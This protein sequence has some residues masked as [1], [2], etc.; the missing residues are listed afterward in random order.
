[1]SNGRFE[2]G[3]RE[4]ED[5]DHEE[6]ENFSAVS[7]PSAADHAGLEEGPSARSVWQ[8]TKDEATLAAI[9]AGP[10][11]GQDQQCSARAKNN[12]Y[13]PTKGSSSHRGHSNAVTEDSQISRRTEGLTRDSAMEMWDPT[14]THQ[15]VS[16]YH[17]DF[18]EQVLKRRNADGQTAEKRAYWKLWSRVME[19][20]QAG[21]IDSA[22][23]EVL[24]SGDELMIV[25]LMNKTG[26]VLDKLSAHTANEMLHTVA[27]LLRQHGFFDFGLPWLQQVY[28]IRSLPS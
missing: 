2:K 3:P 26:P 18:Q 10:T 15:A 1:M 6:V 9:R 13:S 28:R 14:T 16:A 20:V 23:L 17:D 5:S 7:G 22:Y 8:A 24:G 11:T 27:L 21:D 25:R 4:W 19:L 12:T